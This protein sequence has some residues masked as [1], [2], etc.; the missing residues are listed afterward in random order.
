MKTLVCVVALLPIFGISQFICGQ[1]TPNTIR[2]QSPYAVY[3]AGDIDHFN[4]ANGNLFIKIPI[5]SFPQVGHSLDL[6]FNIYY[7]DKQWYIGNLTPRYPTDG[8]Y[9]WY[10][11]TW[12]WD[13]GPL[14][15]PPNIGVY[16]AR[17]QH[18]DFG[19]DESIVTNDGNG[20]YGEY[21]VTTQLYGDFVQEPDGAKHYIGDYQYQFCNTEGGG[22]CPTTYSG[23]QLWYPATDATSFTPKSNGTQVVGPDGLLYAGNTVTDTNSNSVT[24]SSTGWIDSVGRSIPGSNTGPGTPDEANMP[25]GGVTSIGNRDPI[26]GVPITDGI[27]KCPAGTT[28]ARE[29]DIPSHDGQTESYY[30]CY[31]T[32]AFQTHFDDNIPASLS[33]LY[34]TIQE[35]SG[36]VGMLTAIVL[37]N[38]TSY[39]FSYDSYLSLTQLTLPTGGSITYLWT[40]QSLEYTELTI[41]VTRVLRRKIVDPGYGQP[42]QTWNYYY[43]PGITVVT[44]PAGNDTEHQVSYANATDNEDDYYVGCGPHH[45]T[46][47]PNDTDSTCSGSAATASAPLK[48]VVYTLSTYW[49]AVPNSGSLPGQSIGLLEPTTITTTLATSSGGAVASK[50]VRTMTPSYGSCTIWELL[51]A[52]VTPQQPYQYTIP[53]CYFANQLQT[54]TEYDYPSGSQLIN[55]TTNTYRW[56]NTNAA[57]YLSAN[58]LDLVASTTVMDSSGNLVSETDYGYDENNGSPQGAY[59]NQ[60]SASRWYNLGNPSKETTVYNSLGMPTL[61][62]DAN[63]NQ[64]AIQSYQ[65]SGAFPQTV[66]R[67]YQSTSTLPET[68]SYVY[69]C[70]VGKVTS[71]V[72]PNGKTTQFSYDDPLN[73]LKAITYPDLYQNTSQHG[74]TSYNYGDLDS[75]INVVVSQVVNPTTTKQTEYDVDGLGGLIHQKLISDPE[76]TDIIDT[77]YD[78]LGRVYTVSNPYRGTS[79]PVTTY[80]YD[81]LGRKTSQLDADGTGTQTWSYDGSSVTHSDEVGNQW[82][83]TYGALGWLLSVKE[84]GT[85][86]QAPTM[87]TSYTYDGLGNLTSV[88]QNGSGNGSLTR[89]FSY[90]SLSRLIASNNPEGATAAV[91]AKLSCSGA[92]TSH[93]WTTCYTY[94][95]NGNLKSKTDNR[96][97]AVS[98]NYDALDRLIARN[99]SGAT[100]SACFLYDTAINGKGRLGM[101]WTQ[102]GSCPTSGG[103]TKTIVTSRSILAYDPM[104]RIWNEQQCVGSSCTAAVSLTPPCFTSGLSGP[105]FLPYCY[106]LAGNLVYSTNGLA[107]TPGATNPVWFANTYDGASHLN[108]ITSSWNDATHPSPLFSSPLYSA[109]GALTNAIYGS[110]VGLSRTYDNRLRITGETDTGTI[111]TGATP[112]SATVTITGSEQSQ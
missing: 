33:A 20:G 66:V 53:N 22:V 31:T 39:T 54:T 50:E 29:W 72:D 51:G 37:P 2:G 100:P 61:K 88:A 45:P 95:A 16:I 69:D 83:M 14:T 46:S 73:R 23:Y 17:S 13:Y 24:A 98:Y 42:V 81:A 12:S 56:Q 36:T 71:I 19:Q 89:L 70:N 97:V 57:S 44:D 80:G 104:G 7:N 111:I 76:G 63:Q 106:D 77:N 93:Y 65:C 1:V 25:V 18:L 91:P 38:L 8:S 3:E 107:N 32:L 87:L 4:V 26:P 78:S 105:Y 94:D 27:G 59:G 15:P 35:G 112:G 21:V 102:A 108:S 60:T 5:L 47:D 52:S 85:A 74:Q 109:S 28:S 40:N 90:D 48:S 92:D 30:L 34:P 79:G 96:L 75:P 55:T 67:A 6:T 103:P 58:L 11:G 62:T 82:Q 86:S 68:T 49:G 41:P 64:T 101:Q 10:T 43:T 9:A 84:P 110:S 99:H